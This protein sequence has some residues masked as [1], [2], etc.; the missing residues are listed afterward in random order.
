M[1]WV[2][3]NEIGTLVKGRVWTCAYPSIYTAC[4]LRMLLSVAR[5]GFRR[6]WG[7]GRGLLGRGGSRRRRRAFLGLGWLFVLAGGWVVVFSRIDSILWDGDDPGLVG[8]VLAVVVG[9]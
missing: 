4:S 1:V 7:V 3:E 8:W 6:F 9:G 2:L 5:R